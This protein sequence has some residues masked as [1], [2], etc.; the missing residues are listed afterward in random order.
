MSR[1][2]LSRGVVDALNEAPMGRFHM[3]VLFTAGMGFFTDAYDL[4]IIGVALAL[5]KVEYHPS[6]FVIGLVGSTALIAALIGATIFGR[7]ADVFGR[8]AV[9]GLEAALMAVAA[10]GSA[11]S[12]NLVWLIAWR[13]VLGIGIGGD[14]PVSAVIMSEYANRKN[15]G[16]LVSMV[17]SMQALGLIMGPVVA[18]IIL[19]LGVNHDLAWR[20]MLGLGAIPALGVIYLRRKMPESPRFMARVQGKNE[21]AAAALRSYTR[22]QVQA[23]AEVTGPRVR[24]SFR[25]FVSNPRYLFLLV[26]TAGSWFLLDYT[27]YG[28]SISSPLILKALAPHA[29]L[30]Q[31]TALT[32]LVFSLF[33]LPGY[34][35]AFLAIDRVGHRRLQFLGFAGMALGFLLL[36]V[37]PGIVKEVL[38]FVVLYGLSYFFTEFGPNT[39]TFVLPSELYPV[40]AR[41]TGHGLSAGTGK[42][43]AFIGT[44]TFPLVL[45]T[46]GLSGVM[47]IATST[48][49]LGIMVTFLL[50]EPAGKTIEE[51]SSEDEAQADTTPPLRAVNV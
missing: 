11:L 25:Q 29:S 46:L 50:P 36:G 42:V 21:A 1:D 10:V 6:A 45:S 5:I 16:R 4:F 27:F 39:T 47:L 17:F 13:F 19:A 34:I 3:R 49:V 24:L 37:V 23:E 7:V 20:L 9:Y 41:T 51:A 18:L 12:P 8:K 31:D 43:G 35:F 38:P 30:I 15:R 40:S 48:A 32:L 22:D 2:T 44:F 28:N 33:A 14:Y 26:G